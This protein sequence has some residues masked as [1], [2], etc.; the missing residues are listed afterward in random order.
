MINIL[1]ICGSPVKDSNAILILNEALKSII[2]QAGMGYLPC[3]RLFLLEDFLDIF[4]VNVVREFKF[5]QN[6]AKK[7]NLILVGQ[8]D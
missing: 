3:K 7:I 6:N 2:F 8:V 4:F 5:F 1:G